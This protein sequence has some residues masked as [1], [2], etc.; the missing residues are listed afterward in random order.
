MEVCARSLVAGNLTFS[1]PSITRSPSR[2]HTNAHHAHPAAQ[3]TR[4]LTHVSPPQSTRLIDASSRPRHVD[5]GFARRLNTV[6]RYR[7]TR[8]AMRSSQPSFT[9]DRA[10]HIKCHRSAEISPPGLAHAHL[11]ISHKPLP[12]GPTALLADRRVCSDACS[13][14]ANEPQ[15]D[16][17]STLRAIHGTH[18]GGT[19]IRAFAK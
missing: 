5:V 7:G 11:A 4:T 8:S 17:K 6:C 19:H 13:R 1:I 16:I 12:D 2:V 18:R 15:Q 3:R 10:D 14:M 9:L